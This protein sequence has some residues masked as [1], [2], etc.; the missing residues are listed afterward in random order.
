MNTTK[1]WVDEILRDIAQKIQLPP[2]RY[3]EA[4]QHYRAVAEYL[5]AKESPLHAYGP[6]ILY[7]QG[8]FRI[9]S[10]ISSRL[11]QDEFDIDLI[12]EFGNLSRDKDPDAVLDLVVRGLTRGSGDGKYRGCE[13][14]KK[15]RCVTIEYDE[16]H[17]D[18]TPAVFIGETPRTSVIFD[19]HPHRPSHVLSNPEGFALKFEDA[20][21]PREL[22][23]AME[24]A[25]PVPEQKP[26]EAK[27]DRLLALQL[28]KRHRNILYDRGGNKPPSVLLAWFTM[29]APAGDSLI[30]QLIRLTQYIEQNLNRGPLHV[31]NPACPREEFTDRWPANSAE[32]ERFAREL[33]ALRG[34]LVALTEAEE[35]LYAKRDVLR[36]LFGE[37]VTNLAFE[38]LNTRFGVAGPTGVGWRPSTG[39]VSATTAVGSRTVAPHTFFGGSDQERR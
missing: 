15:K 11:D 21:L 19:C 32:Q 37:A 30:S 10:T 23:L 18:I 24:R 13:V 12:L 29:H 36:E 2:S 9:Q 4:S 16:M 35:P 20:T 38:S 8:S 33:G 17:L 26:I 1:G 14:V 5:E 6:L 39:A 28:L 3:G 27:S 25:I 7:P 31:M 22:V 34:A